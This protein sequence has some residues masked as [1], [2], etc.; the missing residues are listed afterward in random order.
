MLNEKLENDSRF[1]NQ[2]KA[3][4]KR[5]RNLIPQSPQN[6]YDFI[7]AHYQGDQDD[8]DHLINEYVPNNCD[9][10]SLENYIETLYKWENIVAE[11]KDLPLPHTDNI[12][13][14]GFCKQF[15]NYVEKCGTC[16]L[17]KIGYCVLYKDSR[18][19]Y[20]KIDFSIDTKS[21]KKLRYAEKMLQ[22]IKEFD[23]R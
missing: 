18:V 13:S 1:I 14:C 15:K 19:L 7:V 11:L 5:F 20:W 4:K 16:P 8:L 9:K 12:Y 6:H 23:P 17:F 2:T 21:Y 10:I 22:K 3:W